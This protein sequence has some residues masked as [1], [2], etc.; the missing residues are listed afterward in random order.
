MVMPMNNSPLKASGF[1]VNIQDKKVTVTGNLGNLFRL[2]SLSREKLEPFFTGDNA[3]ENFTR[4]CG[5][6][7]KDDSDRGSHAEMLAQL[8]T[9]A[10][11]MRA[12]EQALK[13]NDI[14]QAVSKTLKTTLTPMPQRRRVLSEHDGEWSYDR[15]HDILQYNIAKK[16]QTAT[17][18]IT[19]RCHFAASGSTDTKEITRYGAVIWAIVRM[20][21]QSGVQARVTWV[22]ANDNITADYYG[23][24]SEI[25][26]TLKDFGTYIAPSQLAAIFNGIFYRRMGWAF[27]SL[28]AHEFQK[29]VSSGLGQPVA[30]RGFSYEKGIVNLSMGAL[31]GASNVAALCDGI[32]KAIV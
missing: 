31:N 15:R 21:E 8:F 26:I 17:R 30:P 11:N 4:T 18:T 13:H 2:A 1:R 16:L 19:L 10:V 32:R 6:L 20:L 23:D 5:S 3:A 14:A 22:K 9:G 27:I 24:K 12:Y 29:E 28:A 25:E 7:F